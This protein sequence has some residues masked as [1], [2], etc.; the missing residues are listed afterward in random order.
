L[1]DPLWLLSLL[2]N[3]LS[4]RWRR[5]IGSAAPWGL[6]PI[7]HRRFPTGRAAP[8]IDFVV[9]AWL[10]AAPFAIVNSL[11]RWP[12]GSGLWWRDLL[13]V[14]SLADNRIDPTEQRVAA[15][16]VI[17]PAMVAEVTIDHGNDVRESNSIRLPVGRDSPQLERRAKAMPTVQISDPAAICC[18]INVT[19]RGH[20][21]SSL[22]STEAIANRHTVQQ[23]IGLHHAASRGS[24]EVAGATSPNFTEKDLARSPLRRFPYRFSRQVPASA[25]QCGI[26]HAVPSPTMY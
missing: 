10:P 24:E 7:A 26:F 5:F 3:E 6:P 19:D 9:S 16:T 2:D 11:H 8:G 4:A 1:V 21:F 15:A 23:Y 17:S 13:L 20:R 12:A 18:E 25:R 22:Q 14:P